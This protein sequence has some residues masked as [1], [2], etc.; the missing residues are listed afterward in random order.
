MKR[1][2]TS[3]LAAP[4]AAPLVPLTIPM[5]ELCTFVGMCRSTVE[6]LVSKGEFPRPRKIGA[7]IL[8]DRAEVL[9]WWSG[10]GAGTAAGGRG[11]R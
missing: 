6:K 7:K 11:R 9:T 5:R 1:T 4:A 10:Q 2:T 3:A 8:F